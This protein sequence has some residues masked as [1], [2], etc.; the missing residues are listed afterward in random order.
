MPL[1]CLLQQKALRFQG[2]QASLPQCCR[3]LSIPV[4]ARNGKFTKKCWM[5]TTRQ[6]TVFGCHTPALQN[7]QLRRRNKVFI[8]SVHMIGG[9]HN[10]GIVKERASVN[11]TNNKQTAMIV[12]EAASVNT[13]NARCRDCK[14]SSICKHNK[15]RSECTLCEGGS[16][17]EC[18]KK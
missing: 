3:Q 2:R 9:Q 7:P 6:K 11:T 5:Y 15:Q 10:A 4:K 8:R 17:C 16:I 18:G 13:T 12:E 14:G 1:K